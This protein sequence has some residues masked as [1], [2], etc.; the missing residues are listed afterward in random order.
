MRRWEGLVERYLRECEARGLAAST[1]AQRRAALE[2]WG[3]WLRR[4]HPRPRLDEVDAPLVIAYVR[5][6]SAFHSKRTVSHTMYRV[7]LC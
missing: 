7:P 3:A 2:R 1:L 6:R 5:A 4:R